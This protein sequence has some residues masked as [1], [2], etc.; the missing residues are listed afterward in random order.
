MSS[1][2]RP[3]ILVAN[4]D[5]IE[6]PGLHAAVCA[7]RPLGDL[8]IVAPC[9][10]HS[11]AGRS[12]PRHSTGRIHSVTLELT[13]ASLDAFCVEG[14]PAQTV[15]YAL[16][17]L[18][19]RRPDLAVVGINYGENVGGAIT[20]S[21]TVGA[22]IEAA[23]SGIPALAVSLQTLPEFHHS[24]STQMDFGAAAHFVRF[25]ARRLL[26]PG[27]RL[28]PDVDLLKIDVPEDATPDTPWRVTRI[29]RQAY[30]HGIPPE[31]EDLTEPGPL[32]YHVRIEWSELEPDSDIHAL[33]RDRVV[34]V[35]PVSI[36]L[37]SRTDRRSLASLLS[38]GEHAAAPD[39]SAAHASSRR[40]AAASTVRLV[41]PTWDDMAYVRWLWSDPETM[42]P[43][44][45]PVDLTDE[46]AESWFRRMVDPGNPTDCYRLICGEG[47]QPVGEISFHRLDLET[48]TAELNL[49]IA[50]GERGKGYA[51][52]ALPQ[53]LDL[54]F[55]DAGGRVMVDGVALD[56]RRGQQVLLAFGFEHDPTAKDV[57][58][59]RMTSERFRAL[60]PL[61]G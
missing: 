42:H 40:A 20:S 61:Q 25:F 38:G 52:A 2:V 53:F 32:D 7:L 58:L 39:R 45:G 23:I 60:Y 36:D 18:A 10:Q 35:A 21:G 56:N 57:V 17:E 11:G 55:G 6:S 1:H 48:M 43:V 41:V 50:S 3:L 12:F 29:S 51:R 28:P 9:Q 46:R 31:R 4:D 22:A 47:G 49:K 30:L 44:G 33:V 16:F 8:L 19:P 27:V 14:T 24:H 26:S 37:S 13:D 59:L 15:Q 54:F 34:S 5:G